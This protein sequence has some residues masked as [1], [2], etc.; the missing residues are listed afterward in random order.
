MVRGPIFCTRCLPMDSMQAR[1]R[2]AAPSV[3][4]RS[5]PTRSYLGGVGLPQEVARVPRMMRGSFREN[6]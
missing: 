5:R 2:A 1:S 6:R 4:D 3:S